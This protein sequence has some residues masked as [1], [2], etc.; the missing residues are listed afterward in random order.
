MCKN[1]PKLWVVLGRTESRGKVPCLCCIGPLVLLSLPQ[2][3]LGFFLAAPLLLVG[4]FG[5]A[6]LFSTDF[7]CDS[8]LHCQARLA[9]LV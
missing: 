4:R 9:W 5:T 7:I 1:D 8:F 2:A 6:E 3:F